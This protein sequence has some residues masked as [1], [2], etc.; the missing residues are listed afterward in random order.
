MVSPSGRMCMSGAMYASM[1]GPP[2]GESPA[3]RDICCTR[4]G[5]PGAQQAVHRAT[6]ARVLLVADVLAHLDRRGGVVGAVVDVA[7]VQ[8]AE[9]DPVA[10][11]AVGG[12]LPRELELLRDSVTPVTCTP[13][14][15]A[16]WMLSDP[17]PHPTS[18]RRMPGAQ[19]RASRTRSS[20]LARCASASDSRRVLTSK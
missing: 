16:A 14:C 10:Q 8:Q 1:N 7:V 2:P 5:A 9:V 12:A 19:T 20:S 15:S 11:P 17:Q 6:N 4:N 18:S 3:P 13:W